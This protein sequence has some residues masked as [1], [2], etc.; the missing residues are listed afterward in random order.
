MRAVFSFVLG[1]TLGACASPPASC[2]TVQ[3][4]D[5]VDAKDLEAK[6]VA[7]VD[8]DEDRR[9]SA[10]CSGVWLSETVFV[11]ADHC[12]RGQG[13]RY[14]ISK[15][16]IAY[17]AQVVARAPEHDLALFVSTAKPPV[18]GEAKLAP[19]AV[20]PGAKVATMGHPLGLWWSYSSGDVAAIRTVDEKPTTLFIQTTAPTSQGNSGCGLF[21]S[22]GYLVGVGHSIARSGSN[23]S[24]YVHTKHLAA[25]LRSANL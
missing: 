4:E 24:L 20:A 12:V 5:R 16:D 7:L 15:D 21:D 11:T 18:H 1:A 23:I 13:A 22:R 3:I 10:Y 17:A 2:P 6:T 25:L 9:A 8:L 14:A 19:Y